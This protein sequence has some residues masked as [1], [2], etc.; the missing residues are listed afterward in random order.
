[1]SE[2]MAQALQYAHANHSAYLDR[3]CELLRIP[4]IS[5]DPDFRDDVQHAADWLVAEMTAIGLENAQAFATEGQP[6]VYADW[7]HAGADKPTVLVYA[8]YDVQPVIP[9]ESWE[10]KPFEPEIRDDKLY[11]RGAIDDKVGVMVNLHAFDAML[12]TDGRLPVNVKM[13]WEGEEESGSPSMEGFVQAHKELLQADLLIISDGGHRPNQP[14]IISSLRGITDGEVIVRG[15]QRDLHSGSYGGIVHNPIHKVGEII[16]ALHDAD[17]RVQI[18]GFYDDVEV[19]SAE[20]VTAM[21]QHERM[22][23]ANQRDYSGVEHFWGV[24]DYTHMERGATQPTCDVNGVWGGYQGPGLM[25]VIPA[26]AG[27]KVSFRLVPTQ[28]PYDI[29]D[30]FVRWL[31]QFCTKTLSIDVT[32]HS[33]SWAAKLLEAGPAIDALQYAYQAVWGQEAI[34]LRQGGSVPIMGMFQRELGI[35]I[36]TMGFGVGENGHAPNEFLHL[37]YYQ[38]GIDTAIHFYHHLA[39]A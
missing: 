4:S 35:P 22:T 8:H 32:I 18:D 19:V 36:T 13:F 6:V 21:Q 7:L 9:L 38:R 10:S 3:F 12:R 11:A 34:Q 24:P 29:A 33:H 14:S 1:M 37:P 16:G 25:T 39:D 20:T 17:G 23:I 5:T 28:D 15:P 2:T 31:D 27:F 30:K 26:E